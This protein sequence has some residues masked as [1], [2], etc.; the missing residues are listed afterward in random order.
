MDLRSQYPIA[1]ICQVLDYPWSQVYYEAHPVS[2]D[3]D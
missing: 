3:A 1:T 2:D